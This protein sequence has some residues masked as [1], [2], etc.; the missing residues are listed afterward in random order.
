MNV[1]VKSVDAYRAAL[2]EKFNV[3]SRV[4][5]ALFAVRSHF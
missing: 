3:K 4:G 2:F 5:L 1:S